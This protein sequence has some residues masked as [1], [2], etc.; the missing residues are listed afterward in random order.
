M[1]LILGILCEGAVVMAAD[2]AATYGA[3]GRETIRQPAHKLSV[4]AGAAILGVSGPVGLGQ[5]FAGKLEELWHG[6]A[7]SGQQP[8]AVMDRLRNELW[9][10]VGPEIKAASVAASLVGNQIAGSSA[11]SQTLVALPVGGDP[12][13]FQFDQQ[14]APE[15]ATPD[16]PFVAVGSA[17]GTADPFLALLRRIYWPDRLPSLADGLF[18]AVWTVAHAIDTAPGGVAEPIQVAVLRKQGAKCVPRLLE[19]EE[20]E[21]H[22]QA[23]SAA[24][25]HLRE[26]KCELT[27]DGGREAAV[28][29]PG[30]CT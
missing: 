18:A 17:Q 30:E 21:E 5:R 20:L 8:H 9:G 12:C 7:F 19:K 15:Q 1:T 10:Y 24:E 26:F 16:L 22:R 14:C 2:G 3:L 4:V 27:L 11:V 13:L 25:N 29:K 23:R 6:K 28:P